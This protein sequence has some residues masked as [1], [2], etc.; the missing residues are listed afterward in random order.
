MLVGQK[1]TLQ[2]FTGLGK[3]CVL[4]LSGVLELIGSLINN[5]G[6]KIGLI[7]ASYNLKILLFTLF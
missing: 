7:S 1:K 5:T 4:T 3:F 6:L 2:V